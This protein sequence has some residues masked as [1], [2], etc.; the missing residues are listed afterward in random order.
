MIAICL[1]DTVLSSDVLAKWSQDMARRQQQTARS[2]EIQVGGGSHMAATL[3]C[4]VWWECLWCKQTA[5]RSCG[6]VSCF[7]V[8]RGRRWKVWLDA[9]FR[10]AD[11]PTN[12][13]G[14]Y[15][16]T[17]IRGTRR[18]L[19][20]TYEGGEF[21]KTELWVE[22]SPARHLEPDVMGDGRGRD[23][24]RGAGGPSLHLQQRFPQKWTFHSCE[25][26]MEDWPFLGDPRLHP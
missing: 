5:W 17:C 25:G 15:A 22:L 3:P 4:N 6:A 23:T 9:A 21:F 19:G 14:L 10:W 11:P 13:E 26:N 12:S 18:R 1:L 8:V 24:R 7:N 16:I 2:R 20:S